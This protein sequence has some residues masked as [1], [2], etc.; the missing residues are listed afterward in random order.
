MVNGQWSIGILF[1]KTRIYFSKTRIGYLS[2][3]TGCSK[4]RSVSLKSSPVD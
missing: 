2:P 3:R 1:V 4:R